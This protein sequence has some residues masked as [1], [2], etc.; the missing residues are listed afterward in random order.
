MYT[1]MT[2][3]MLQCKFCTYDINSRLSCYPRNGDLLA[4]KWWLQTFLFTL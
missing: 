1:S 2:L 3:Q 4:G